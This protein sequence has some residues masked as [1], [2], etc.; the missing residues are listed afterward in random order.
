MQNNLVKFVQKVSIASLLL[1]V[2]FSTSFANTTNN[3]SFNNEVGYEIPMPKGELTPIVILGKSE[4]NFTTPTESIGASPTLTPTLSYATDVFCVPGL[5]YF[6]PTPTPG[7]RLKAQNAYTWER[8]GDENGTRPAVGLGAIGI[9]PVNGIIGQG[10]SLPGIYAVTANYFDGTTASTTIYVNSKPTATL[11][12]SEN[13]IY[14]GSSSIIH[15]DLTAA[16]PESNYDLV[17]LETNLAD[18]STRTISILNG[19]TTS[20]LDDNVGLI[21]TASLDITVTPTSTTPGSYIQYT[22]NIQP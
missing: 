18:N 21:G 10:N 1:L 12:E 17:L 19:T 5:L 2:T 16:K 6:N 22:Y 20:T 13:T 14:S 9:N 7:K 8:I 11:T 15:V 3:I 4:S